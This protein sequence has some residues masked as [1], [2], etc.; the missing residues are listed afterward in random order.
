[1]T[2][3]ALPLAFV[4]LAVASIGVWVSGCRP[5]TASNANGTTK[6]A[7]AHEPTPE[8][9]FQLV[10]DTFRRAVDT[11]AGAQAG[12]LYRDQDGHSS[13]SIRKNVTDNL[14]A[15]SKEGE[16]YRG[17]ITVT[18][19]FSYSL[20]MTPDADNDK[21]GGSDKGKGGSD[22]RGYGDDSSDETGV[23]VL[24]KNLIAAVTKSDNPSPLQTDQVVARRTDDEV[25]TYEL[26]YEDGRWVLKTKL[27]PKTE[28]SIQYAFEHALAS[29]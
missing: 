20:H 19:Q 7:A 21:L 16:S 13:L 8:E 24:D 14:I 5:G 9:S 4:A 29:Q 15:P 28:Q 3:V 18:S 22:Q 2:R 11:D 1:M 27:D 26:A 17:T 12:F 10:V 23:D 6:A 25:R